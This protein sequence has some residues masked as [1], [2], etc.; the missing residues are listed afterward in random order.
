[1]ITLKDLFYNNDDED[2]YVKVAADHEFSV[3]LGKWK[4]IAVEMER[5]YDESKRF[6][7]FC[8]YGVTTDEYLSKYPEQ[9]EHISNLIDT[10]GWP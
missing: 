3:Q 8:V 6:G 2:W 10:V 7:W 4:G 1:M 5:G 9:S